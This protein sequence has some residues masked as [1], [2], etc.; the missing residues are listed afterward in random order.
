MMTSEPQSGNG[1]GHN[2]RPAFEQF[3]AIRRYQ[4]TLAFSLD[5]SEIAYSVNTSGQYNLW[6]QPSEGGYPHQVTLSGSQAVRQIAWSPDG[7]SLLYTADNDGDE[8]TKI[9]Q[10]SVRGGRPR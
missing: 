9:Y 4:N 1:A 6:R 2:A 8:F 7:E 5:G 10:V 3:T